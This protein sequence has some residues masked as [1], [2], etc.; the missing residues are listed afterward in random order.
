[1]ACSKIVLRHF[2][3]LGGGEQFFAVRTGNEDLTSQWP[4]RTQLRTVGAVEAGIGM[5]T[6]Q[7]MAEEFA[8]VLAVEPGCSVDKASQ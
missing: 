8:A 6:T 1:M 5:R 2:A 3:V 4:A 7:D